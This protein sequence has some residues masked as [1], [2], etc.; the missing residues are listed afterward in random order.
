MAYL[1]SF[2]FGLL[3]VVVGTVVWFFWTLSVSK[4]LFHNTTLSFNLD[5]KSPRV[6]IPVACLFIAGFVLSWILTTTGAHR[7]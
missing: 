6:W 7:R 4:K 1:K 2:V 3:A 5:L